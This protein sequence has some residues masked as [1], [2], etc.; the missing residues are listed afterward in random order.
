MRPGIPGGADPPQVPRDDARGGGK[1][2]FGRLSQVLEGVSD[3]CRW[4]RHRRRAAS[5]PEAGPRIQNRG[6][7]IN[8]LFLFHHTRADPAEIE[9]KG[10]S[11]R[12]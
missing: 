1:P 6:D 11:Q 5:Y 4:G 7:P 10:D 2:A 3:F 12:S 9:S 8:L